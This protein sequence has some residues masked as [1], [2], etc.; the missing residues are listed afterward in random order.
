[1]P[2]LPFFLLAAK[3]R[4]KEKPPTLKT[5]LKSDATLIALHLDCTAKLRISIAFII[6]VLQGTIVW[7]HSSTV[8]E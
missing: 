2:A 1:M 3:E 7:Q 4:N 6:Q 5:A 8:A